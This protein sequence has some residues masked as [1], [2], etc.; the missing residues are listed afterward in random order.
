MA[1]LLM[2]F[3]TTPSM[4]SRFDELYSSATVVADTSSSNDIP[5]GEY[6]T[7]V[8]DVALTNASTSTPTMVWTFRIREGSYS[9]RLLRKVRPVTDRTI[10]WVKEDLT[11]FG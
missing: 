7:V 1:G 3:T 10:T 11:K 4:L 6:V 5:D 9:D 8:E 2:N